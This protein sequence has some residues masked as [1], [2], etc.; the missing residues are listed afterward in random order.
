MPSGVDVQLE[1]THEDHLQLGWAGAGWA[2]AGMT[3]FAMG[4]SRVL[5]SQRD[6]EVSV[7]SRCASGDQ[8]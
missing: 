3:S 8:G 4:L 6:G 2:G 1:R 7:P 5:E